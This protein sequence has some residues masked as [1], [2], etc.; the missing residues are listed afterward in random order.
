MNVS[1]LNIDFLPYHFPECAFNNSFYCTRTLFHGEIKQDIS[2]TLCQR[3]KQNVFRYTMTIPNVQFLCIF[4]LRSA[5]VSDNTR[6]NITPNIYTNILCSVLT[7]FITETLKN[8]ETEQCILLS[9]LFTIII[10]LE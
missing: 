9:L 3:N 6:L 1:N 4:T 7:I 5:S 10:Y 8:L 2:H